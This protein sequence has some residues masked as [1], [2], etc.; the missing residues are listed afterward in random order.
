[1]GEHIKKLEKVHRAAPRWVPTFKELNYEEKL[2]KNNLPNLGER[3]KKGDT[4]T[5]YK[6]MLDKEKLD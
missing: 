6:C 2:R 1:M 5:M 4:I 3:Q